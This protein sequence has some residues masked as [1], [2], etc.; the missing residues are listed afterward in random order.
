M[1]NDNKYLTAALYYAQKL[2]WSVFPVSEKTKKPHTPHGCKDAKKDPQVIRAWWKRWPGASIGVATG[3]ASNLLVID[4]DLDEDKG[5]DGMRE[6]RDWE[7]EHGEL[8]ETVSSITGRGGSHLYYRYDGSTEY[9]NRAGILTGVDVRAEGGYVIAPPS[10][11]PNGTEYQWENDPNEIELSDINDT[12]KAFLSIGSTSHNETFAMPATIGTGK[13]NDTM[14]RFACSMQSKGASD[15]AIYAAVKA[16][17]EAR[18]KPPLAEDEIVKIVSSALKYAKGEADRIQRAGEWHEPR[19]KY[20]LDKDGNPSDRPAQTIANAMEAIEYDK[21]LFG[22]LYYNEMTYSPYVYGSLPWRQ[23]AG[24]REWDNTDDTNL[25]SYIEDKYGLKS[26]D[27]TMDA[28][29]NVVHKHLANPVKEMLEFSH[30]E[31]DG[32][33]HIENLLPLVTG[34]EKT[35]YNTAVLHLFMMGAVSRVFKPGCKFDYMM[36]LVGE[37]GKYKSSFLR[38]LATNDAWCHDNFNSLDGD[39]AFEKLRGKWIVE[40]A[41]LQATK[42][43]KDVES[44]KAFITS[45]VDTYRAPYMRRS[46][47]HP[48]TC[49]LAGTSNPV[50]FL[51]DRTGNRRFLP[52]A[53]GITDIPNPFDKMDIIRE[54]VFQAWGEVM[55]EY[56]RCGGKVSLVLSKEMQEKAQEMQE[57]FLEEDPDVGIIQAWL[58]GYTDD[59]VCAIQLWKEALVRDTDRYTRKDINAIHEIMKNSI[60]GWKASGKQRCGKYGVQRAYE[61]INKTEVVEEWMESTNDD[62]LPFNDD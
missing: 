43:A 49:V 55:D 24:W 10:M 50:D 14:Y 18:C 60:K 30:H 53:C 32:N 16:E 1:G 26:G 47:D 8:P 19:I 2:N 27:K 38:F 59:R 54:E 7:K 29:N 58:E 39:K 13:R 5:Y 6:L 33:K 34:S 51:T 22:R 37:Q 3:K 31:W 41:E 44:I 62:N 15:E 61:R 48:R 42:R 36:V 23:Y 17:N 35:E 20:A 21:E 46:E 12:V 57:A 9:K 25:K 56:L 40:L 28:L 11:H 52:V 45:T 4:L